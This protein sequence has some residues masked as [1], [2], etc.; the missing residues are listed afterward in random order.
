MLVRNAR[1]HIPGYAL[2]GGVCSCKVSVTT[3]HTTWCVETVCWSKILITIYQAS[4]EV[5]VP[6][7]CR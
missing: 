6:A 7:K 3:G 4:Q 2:S 5:C 1:N